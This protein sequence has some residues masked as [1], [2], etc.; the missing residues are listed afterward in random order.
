MNLFLSRLSLD[1]SEWDK[2]LE[3]SP[4]TINSDLSLWNPYSAVSCWL[5]YL[6]SME[7]GSPPLYMELNR[8]ARE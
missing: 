3:T 7:L 1:E 4:F 8:A 2:P 5:L 6:Y